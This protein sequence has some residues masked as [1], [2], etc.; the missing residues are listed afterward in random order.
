MKKN[1]LNAAADL[2]KYMIKLSKRLWTQVANKGKWLRI[3]VGEGEG[4][5]ELSDKDKFLRENFQVK[6]KYH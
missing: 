2:L 5:L 4:F 1:N 6:E 3:K